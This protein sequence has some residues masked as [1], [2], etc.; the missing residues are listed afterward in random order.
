MKLDFLLPECTGRRFK[1]WVTEK[2]QDI[3]NTLVADWLIKKENQPCHG[4]SRIEWT[5][6]LNLYFAR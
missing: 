3:G 2:D 6:G 5:S 4:R 1:T